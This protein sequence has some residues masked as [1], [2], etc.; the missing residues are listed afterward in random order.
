MKILNNNSDE[1]KLK[2]TAKEL[3]EI[4]TIACSQWKS[5]IA[6]Y[7]SRIDEKGNVLFT[8]F[9]IQQMIDACTKE[10]L[11]IVSKI[12]NYKSKSITKEELEN[13]KIGD[14]VF[15]K[16]NNQEVFVYACGTID[17]NKPLNLIMVDKNMYLTKS[18][19]K[20]KNEDNTY[21]TF[22]QQGN[23][24]VFKGTENKTEINFITKI[25]KK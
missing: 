12:F 17:Y 13:L 19:L 11:P 3:L 5:N 2:I 7:M 20:F 1:L 25:N 14:E 6:S 18:E 9:E 8:E 22:F 15:L 24:I 4:H 21:Y 16:S 23:Y 10:Q